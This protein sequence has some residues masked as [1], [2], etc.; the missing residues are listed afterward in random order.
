MAKGL[1]KSDKEQYT[2]YKAM[3]KR[4]VNRLARLKR[5]LKAQPNDDQ[6][7]TALSTDGTQR[8]RSG[9]R[10]CPAPTDT[11]Q[12]DGSGKRALMGSFIPPSPVKKAA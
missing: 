12:L 3:S 5:H 6:A 7:T 11:Y 9:G 10:E 1:H 2:G 8:E 4:S